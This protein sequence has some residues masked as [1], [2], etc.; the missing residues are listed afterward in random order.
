MPNLGGFFD[1]PAK[2]SEL[3]KLEEQISAQGFWDDAEAAQ[4]VVQQRSRI[5]KSLGRQKDFE[6]GVSD[7]EVL[8]EFA[9]EDA[10][11]AKELEAGIV[12]VLP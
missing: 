3:D 8:F 1:A 12:M 11:S 4:K 7:A 6:T 5:E 10:D 2:Q 9:A